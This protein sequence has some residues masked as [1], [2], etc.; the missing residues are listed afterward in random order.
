MTGVQTC[1]L[2]IS[3]PAD[4]IMIANETSLSTVTVSV[5]I[6]LVL[7]GILFVQTQSKKVSTTQTK[8]KNP[9]S[10][11]RKKELQKYT[12]EEVSKHNNEKDAWII[13]DGRVYDITEYDIHP[14]LSLSCVSGRICS[15]TNLERNLHV[16]DNSSFNINAKMH[17][18]CS[19]S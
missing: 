19:Y 10:A 1:A 3:P 4:N 2:P 6:A 13:V 17:H 11:T 15:E 16:G 18:L 9:Q 8:S 14:G 12:R 7:I 5:L